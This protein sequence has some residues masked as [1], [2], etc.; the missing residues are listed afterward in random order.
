MRP[1]VRIN[2][3]PF[4]SNDCIIDTIEC[5]K[6]CNGADGKK[7]KILFETVHRSC[8]LNNR[9]CNFNIP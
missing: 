1:L 3:Y 4:N 9:H 8:Y 5:L 6:E 2:E 7:K